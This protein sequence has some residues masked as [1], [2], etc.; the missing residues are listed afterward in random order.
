MPFVRIGSL[1]SFPP[2]SLMHAEIGGNSYAI[3][4]VEGELHAFDGTCPHAGGPLGYGALHGSTLVCPWHAWEFDCRSGEH[5]YNPSIRLARHNLI[6]E[7]D[8]ILLDGAN[9]A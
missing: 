2:G 3:C 7:G 1:A 6:V 4:N 5:D 9:D 8:D